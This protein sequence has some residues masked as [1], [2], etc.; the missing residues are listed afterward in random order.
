MQLTAE[1]QALIDQISTQDL[2]GMS[3]EEL[4]QY[5]DSLSNAAEIVNKESDDTQG[6]S[7]LDLKNKAKGM[8][9]GLAQVDSKQNLQID[10]E[11]TF[12]FDPAK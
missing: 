12:K 10:E 6:L 11:E 9:A 4:Q 8:G 7:L 1:Q 3:T 2:E 5:S